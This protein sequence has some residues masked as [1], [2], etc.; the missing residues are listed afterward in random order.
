MRSF[1]L[2]GELGWPVV[3]DVTHSLQ[4]P[5]GD[6][7]AGDRR[8]AR[9]LAR[10]A[11]ATGVDA[12]FLETHPD[13]ARALSDAATQLPLAEVPALLDELLAVRAALRGAGAPGSTGSPAGP[14]APGYG[15][16]PAPPTV[17]PAT[18]PGN[19]PGGVG[20]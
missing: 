4:R 3:Y 18:M 12:V 9:P 8:F 17:A 1:I 6:V 7:T 11:V 15:A 5:G 20:E 19:V 10:A 16:M 2:M 14:A 13:P